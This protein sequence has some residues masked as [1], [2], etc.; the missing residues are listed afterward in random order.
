MRQLVQDLKKGKME[1]LEVSYPI[2]K[3]GHVLVKNHYSAISAGTEGKTVSDA[4]LGYIQK[5]QA[6]KKEVMQVVDMAK[7]QG[8]V[9][10]YKLVMNKLEAPSSLGYSC[11]GEIIGIGDGVEGFE[12]GDYVACGGAGANHSEVV[13]IPKNLCVK[14]PKT[15]NLKYGAITTI[16]AIAMQGVRQAN[17]SIGENV[18]VIGLGLIGQLTC[19]FIEAAGGTAIGIEILNSKLELA[20]KCGIKH[21]LNSI[22]DNVIASITNLTNGIL[23][24]SV[25]ITAATDSQSPFNLAGDIVRKKGNVVIVGG[26]PTDINPNRDVF[27]K[28]EVDIR[29]STSYGPGRYDSV[30]EDK[31]IDY[32]VGHVR[33]TENRNMQSYIKLLEQDKLTVEP[34]IT[35]NFDFDQAAQ[36][37]DMIVNKN[38]DY[39]GIV[40]KYNVGRAHKREIFFDKNKKSTYSEKVNLG[41]VG[42]GS[43]AQNIL[44][45]RIDK[46][47]NFVGVA[48]GKGNASRYVAEKYKFEYSTDDPQKLFNDEK[49][50]TLFVI[51]RHDS[52]AK[53]VLEGIQKNKHVFVEKPLALTMTELKEIDKAVKKGTYSSKLLVGYNR[54]FAPHIEKIKAQLDDSHPKS[55]IYR[56]NAGYVPPQDWSQDPEVGGGRI[57]GEGC[58]FI[59][60]VTFLCGSKVTKVYAQAMKDVHNTNDTVSINLSFENG[61]VGSVNY[62]ANGGKS[63]QKEYIE[64]YSNGT[65]YI[66]DDFKELQ[67]HGKSKKKHKLNKQDKGH[68]KEISDFVNSI[69]N[70][71]PSPISYEDLYQSSLITFKCLE[72]VKSGQSIIID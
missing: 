32:P 6:R 27:Y 13:V 26:V 62:F 24:D 25:I 49:I 45:P 50:N 55:V 47:Q 54:R 57:I 59:D 4:R 19:Q 31:G 71:N 52:H 15:V 48:T 68:T 63:L 11:A 41:L 43:F 5:A 72:S 38:Q 18:A 37:Y 46:K 67:V 3:K 35:H 23:A 66:V 51:T 17:I 53:Y 14:V 1:L 28:K 58:H 69:L 2:L 8:L 39:T 12:I 61:S 21:L 64:V 42:A 40:L 9:D 16:A 70:N 29:I 33:W 20:K 22:N 10:T 34:L 65:T 56:V 36:A 60:L 44:L 7:K 30:Y